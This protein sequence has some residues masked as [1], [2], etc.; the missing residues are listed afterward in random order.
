MQAS[1]CID[2]EKY[3]N[4]VIIILRFQIQLASVQNPDASGFFSLESE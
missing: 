3:S 2:E 1:V 4:G